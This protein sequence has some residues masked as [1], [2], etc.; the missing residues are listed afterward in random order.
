M[1]SL[2]IIYSVF[3][4]YLTLC[5]E[6][7]FDDV[8]KG[9]TTRRRILINLYLEINRCKGFLRKPTLVSICFKISGNSLTLVCGG[10][11]LKIVLGLSFP[12]VT[13]QYCLLLRCN[14]SG[15]N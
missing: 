9:T 10:W 1:P 13:L 8:S 2:F 6:K 12:F 14:V 11:F 5:S 7:G 3:Y 4:S 15:V